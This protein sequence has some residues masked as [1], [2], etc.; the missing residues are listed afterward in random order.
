MHLGNSCYISPLRKC[1]CPFINSV[2]SLTGTCSGWRNGEDKAGELGRFLMRYLSC[3][4]FYGFSSVSRL[5][6]TLT[7][8]GVY[9]S[10]SR[11][12]RQFGL[13]GPIE[14]LRCMSIAAWKGYDHEEHRQATRRGLLALKLH[15][16]ITVMSVKL[17][18]TINFLWRHFTYSLHLFQRIFTSQKSSMPSFN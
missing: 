14:A 7:N 4:H 5:Y 6:E 18:V 16:D 3:I 8:F 10:T 13:N 15:Q 2:P 9:F 11:S 17:C 1:S 12:S